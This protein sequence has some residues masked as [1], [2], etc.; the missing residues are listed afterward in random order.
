MKA[1]PGE[2][3]QSYNLHMNSGLWLA[4]ELN[5]NPPHVDPKNSLENCRGPKL[6]HAK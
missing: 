3:Q 2:I 4:C 1:I 5:A 6:R